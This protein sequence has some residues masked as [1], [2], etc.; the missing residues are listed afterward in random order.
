M[1]AY[2]RTGAIHLLVVSGLHVSALAVVLF[3]CIGYPLRLIS[4]GKAGAYAQ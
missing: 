4:V 1:G 3:T 2:R